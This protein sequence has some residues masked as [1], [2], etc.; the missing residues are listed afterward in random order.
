MDGAKPTSETP[1]DIS[2]DVIGRQA[3]WL[4]RR[5][6]ETSTGPTNTENPGSSKQQSVVRIHTAESTR[7]PGQWSSDQGK[8]ILRAWLT[9]NARKGNRFIFL[10]HADELA[11]EAGKSDASR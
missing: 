1:E 10:Y 2:D 5:W 6:A 7:V 8:S 4:D 9:S 3:C 11:T